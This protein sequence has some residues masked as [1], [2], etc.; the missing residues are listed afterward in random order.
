MPFPRGATSFEASA[1]PKRVVGRNCPLTAITDMPRICSRNTNSCPGKRLCATHGDRIGDRRWYRP[2]STKEI[3][4]ERVSE[5][6]SASGRSFGV[7]CP[8][9]GPGIFPAGCKAKGLVFRCHSISSAAPKVES[10]LPHGR[11][12]HPFRVPRW[13]NFGDPSRRTAI[14]TARSRQ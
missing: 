1:N 14:P 12:N 7:C 3:T 5:G 11:V 13:A 8:R 9:S 10:G 4:P 6:A 2:C